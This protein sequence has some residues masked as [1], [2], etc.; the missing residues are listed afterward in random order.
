MRS[1]EKWKRRKLNEER[2]SKKWFRNKKW[3]SFIQHELIV[4]RPDDYLDAEKQKA[5]EEGERR[6]N[7]G[8]RRN[9]NKQHTAWN[10]R[11]NI[12]I[13]N[14]RIERTT[15]YILISAYNIISTCSLTLFLLQRLKREMILMRF[16]PV[17]SFINC[18][19]SFLRTQNLFLLFLC[20]F[21]LPVQWE[22]EM[23]R[24]GL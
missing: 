2:W 8:G 3:F 10:E 22:L 17:R 15:L 23:G 13:F 11:E 21:I 19:Q 7:G 24:T 9:F 5:A 1:C 14:L 4:C 16:N 18:I 20:C 12:K 6:R